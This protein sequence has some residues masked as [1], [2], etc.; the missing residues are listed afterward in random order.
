MDERLLYVVIR[1]F[2]TYGYKCLIINIFGSTYATSSLYY[3]IVHILLA[4]IIGNNN[5]NLITAS[6]K[7]KHLKFFFGSDFDFGF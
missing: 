1:Q 4:Y 3:C 6:E 7:Q 5:Y 2:K